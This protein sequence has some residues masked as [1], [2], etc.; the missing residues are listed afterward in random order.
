MDGPPPVV[1]G[2]LP[3]HFP[4]PFL[5]LFGRNHRTQLL[6]LE[7]LSHALQILESGKLPNEHRFLSSTSWLQ[8][9]RSRKPAQ[10]D[11]IG[12]AYHHWPKLFLWSGHM[13]LLQQFFDL[14][15]RLAM[16]GPESVSWAPVAND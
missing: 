10:P 2:N 7:R 16:G 4:N 6:R 1:V 15:G 3:R 8:S 9:R 11:Y 5:N 12:S 13:L 14:L